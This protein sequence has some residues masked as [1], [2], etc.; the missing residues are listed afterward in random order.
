MVLLL[1]IPFRPKVVVVKKPP[2]PEEEQLREK[3]YMVEFAAK[4]K[5]H[6]NTFLVIKLKPATKNFVPNNT[7][8]R[9]SFTEKRT[10][11]KYKLQDFDA[12]LGFET[13]RRAVQGTCRF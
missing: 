9:C 2:T 11:L 8:V 6:K 3:L 4:L 1:R 7:I 5:E 10:E 12:D 13:T